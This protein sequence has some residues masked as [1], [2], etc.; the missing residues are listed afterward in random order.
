MQAIMTTH[1]MSPERLGINERIWQETLE[2][3]KLFSEAFKAG[4]CYLCG[5]ALTKFDRAK[6]CL[7][8]LLKPEGFGKK[9]FERLAK[10]HSW[11]ALESYL[12]WVANEEAIAKNINDLAAE[13]TGKLVELT[14]MYKN[15]E[16]SFSCGANDLSGHEGGGEHSK[17]P[18]YHFQ[19]SVDGKPFIRYN[20]FHLPLSEA[21]V[22]VLEYMRQNPGKV[23]RLLPGGAGMNDALDEDMLGQHLDRMKPSEETESALVK[24]RTNIVAEP[25]KKISGDDLYHL[26]QAAKAEGVT[27][28][29]KMHE[30]KG[31]S[32]LTLVF[33]GPSVARQATRSGRKR[34][35]DRV[36][37]D[38]LPETTPVVPPEKTPKEPSKRHP[39][40]KDAART[41][42]RCASSKETQIPDSTEAS[43]NNGKCV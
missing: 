17:R 21:D 19:M 28:A 22:G 23:R 32:V 2:E 36:S 18:H 13:G 8:W 3:H 7:H 40:P 29:S 4:Q 25:G 12:R 24:F 35:G 43:Q 11:A 31:A 20:D 9:H 27:A 10:H 39:Q 1:G 38:K 15:L 30:L 42:D 16:W 41:A 6:P 33:P 34:P 14:I 37:A 5:D 26:I